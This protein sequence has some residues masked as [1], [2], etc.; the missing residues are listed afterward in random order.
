MARHLKPSLVF[1]NHYSISKENEKDEV[2]LFDFDAHFVNSIIHG[3]LTSEIVIDVDIDAHFA[4]QFENC[5]L[6]IN[7]QFDISDTSLFVN[8]ITDPTDLPRFVNPAEGD[9]HL[10]TLSAAKD[11]GNADYLIDFPFDLDGVA[12]DSLPDLGAYERIE[13]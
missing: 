5:M 3:S 11:K 7:P 13:Q 6:K 8:M 12:R 2:H 9:F 4:F 10:D 1:N